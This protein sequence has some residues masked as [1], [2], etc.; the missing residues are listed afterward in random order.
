MDFDVSK[1]ELDDTATLTVQNAKGDDDLIGADGTSP[2]TIMLYGGGSRQMVKALHKAGQQAQIR[3]QGL[4]RGKID[5][6]A[7][8][9]ADQEMVEKLATCTQAINN[10]PVPAADLYANPKLKYITAQVMKFLDDDS[11]FAPA[12]TTNLPSGSDKTPG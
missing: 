1:Y 8:E 2:V 11:N 7:P 5:K 9:L 4:V 3:L 12:S 10:F 6:R